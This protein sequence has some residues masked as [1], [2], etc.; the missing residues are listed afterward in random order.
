M[1]RVEGAFPDD[2]LLIATLALDAV[3]ARAHSGE[4]VACIP[5]LMRLGIDDH[6][7]AAFELVASGWG[8]FTSTQRAALTHLLARWWESTL[9][10]PPDTVNAST[11]LACLARLPIG[12]AQWEQAW[13]ADLDEWP[14]AHLVHLILIG[15]DSDPWAGIPG[16]RDEVRGWTR[17]EPVLFGLT[18]VAGAHL[19]EGEL[20]LVLDRLVD[21]EP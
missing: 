9:G 6:E 15:L 5:R 21:T 17:T 16:R 1:E 19:S 13:L 20:A 11:V 4:L 14:A 10:V 18:M 3:M 8:D 2:S 12:L 7:L